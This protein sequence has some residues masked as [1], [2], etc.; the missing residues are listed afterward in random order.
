MLECD[1]P[2]TG[3]GV[4]VKKEIIKK[5]IISII[6]KVLILRS[7]PSNPAQYTHTSHRSENPPS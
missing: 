4:A 5:L 7:V 3:K 1:A 6:I 2:G